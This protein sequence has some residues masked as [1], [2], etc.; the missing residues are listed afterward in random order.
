M[1]AWLLLLSAAS[2]GRIQAEEETYVPTYVPGGPPEPAGPRM[3]V[4]FGG[5]LPAFDLQTPDT[6]TE[7]AGDAVSKLGLTWM[8]DLWYGVPGEP[9]APPIAPPILGDVREV[10][11]VWFYGRLGFA[12]LGA[13]AGGI[14]GAMSGISARKMNDALPAITNALA[15]VQFPSR[16][17]PLVLAL[18]REKLPGAILLTNQLPNET[19]FPLPSLME[20]VFPLPPELQALKKSWSDVRAFEGTDVGVVLRVVNWGLSGRAGHDPPLSVSLVL[21]GTLIRVQERVRGRSFYAS[22]ESAK[23]PFVS[24]AAN[25]G[26]P[27]RDELWRGVESIANQIAAQLPVPPPAP[28]SAPASVAPLVGGL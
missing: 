6:K 11:L 13:L 4:G 18:I 23:Q 28:P 5:E 12:P 25:G 21:K 22:Y 19:S 9:E 14:H 20:T 1:W 3:G 26:K 17:E 16:F 24:W 27:L 10:K 7:V 15:E 2:S 8:R